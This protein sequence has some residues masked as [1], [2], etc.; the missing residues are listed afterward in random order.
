VPDLVE[1]II[2]N[3]LVTASEIF[4]QEMRMLVSKKL[5]EMKKQ[6]AAKLYTETNSNDLEE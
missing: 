2:K 5:V 3:D 6:T 1:A 4:E